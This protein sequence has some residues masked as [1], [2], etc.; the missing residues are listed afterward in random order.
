M[1]LHMD[2]QISSETIQQN[3]WMT[4]R[5]MAKSDYKYEH[6]ITWVTRDTHTHTYTSLNDKLTHITQRVACYTT[7]SYKYMNTMIQAKYLNQ[8]KHICT[9]VNIH[10]PKYP[11]ASPLHK[12][13]HINMI[14]QVTYLRKPEHIRIQIYV[15]MPKNWRARPLHYAKSDQSFQH[16]NAG[17]CGFQAHKHWICRAL[18]QPDFRHAD[19]GHS[20]G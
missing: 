7:Y 12:Y 13:I 2:F 4:N 5:W 15:Y 17:A 8:T 10:I 6:S 14:I 1:Y 16:T 20:S 3:N 11:R 18:L 9:Q 19:F